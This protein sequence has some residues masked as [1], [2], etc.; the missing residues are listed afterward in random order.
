MGDVASSGRDAFDRRAWRRAYTDLKTAAQAGPLEVA[1]LERLASAAFLIGLAGDSADAWIRAHSE[2]VQA[3]DVERA[4]RC[5]FWLAFAYL[6]GGDLA[7]GGGWV[8]RGSR[9]LADAGRHCVEVGYLTYADALRAIFHGEVERALAGFERAIEV[10]VEFQNA[11]LLALARIGAGRCLIFLGR[12]ASGIALLDEAMAAVS[13]SELSAIA[14]GDAYCTVIEGCHDVF[15]VARASEWTAALSRWCDAQPDLV[16]YRGQCLVHR[17]EL[18]AL[19]G[20]WAEALDEADRARARL[21]EPT[22]QPALSAATYLVGELHRMTGRYDQAEQAYHAAADAGL[23]PQPGL[24]LLRLAQGRPDA[25]AAAM[26]RVLSESGDPAARARLLGAAVEI[27]LAVGNLA[28]GR[29]GAEEL[30][31]IAQRLASPFLHA[32]SSEATGRVLLTEDRHREALPTLRLA[33]SSWHRLNAVFF[34]ARV[35]VLIAQCCKAV[36]DEDGAAMELDAARVV[37]GEL[38]AGPDLRHADALAGIA[39]T[40]SSGNLTARELE[41]IALVAKGLTNRQIANALL[42]SEKTVASHLNHVF[43]K[44]DL[45]SR[46]ALTAYAYEQGLIVS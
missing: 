37:F 29:A 27:W 5:A 12:T 2:S 13:A 1:D 28:E 46:A 10:G 6:N 36:G 42:I 33:W 34:A 39:E 22:P 26:G 30:A 38:G 25:A 8:D 7:Q 9:L 32:V 17:A 21:V 20:E 35:R 3:G 16:L 18:M 44:L 40:T 4:A 14:T 24:A 15:D 11:E 23:D 31:I 45:Q 43:T 41:V 19:H